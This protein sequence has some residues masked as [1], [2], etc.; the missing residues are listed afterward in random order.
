MNKIRYFSKNKDLK[1]TE[2]I[3]LKF[4]RLFISLVQVKYAADRRL[5]M[6]YDRTNA[7]SAEF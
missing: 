2:K 6:Q 1:K 4:T 7:L 5:V 3:F